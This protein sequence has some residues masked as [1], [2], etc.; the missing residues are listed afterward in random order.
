M[1]GF[2]LNLANCKQS[3]LAVY[4]YTLFREHILSKSIDKTLPM[5]PISVVNYSG[6]GF[7]P[8]AIFAHDR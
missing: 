7:E 2:S 8:R 6:R 4:G 3:W 1:S 5:D